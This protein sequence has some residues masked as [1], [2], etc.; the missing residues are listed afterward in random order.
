M[1]NKCEYCK[2]ILSFE[3]SILNKKQIYEAERMG[4]NIKNCPFCGRKLV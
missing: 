3:Y 4:I 2:E 1:S